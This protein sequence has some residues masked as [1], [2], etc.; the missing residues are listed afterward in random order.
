MICLLYGCWLI[1]L[2]YIWLF[3]LF[4]FLTSNSKSL[5][6]GYIIIVS[7]GN[8]I[9]LVCVGIYLSIVLDLFPLVNCTFNNIVYFCTSNYYIAHFLY[10]HMHKCIAI[11][12][13]L[14]TDMLINFIS[15]VCNLNNHCDEY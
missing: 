6:C 2:I 13:L 8:L 15:T 10:I 1:F 14:S 3:G 7:R 4:S 11:N 9:L 12:N 5:F